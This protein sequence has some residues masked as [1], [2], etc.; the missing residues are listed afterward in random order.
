[1]HMPVGL[2]PL[3]APRNEKSRTCSV[4]TVNGKSMHTLALWLE[5]RLVFWLIVITTLLSLY[6]KDVVLLLGETGV[7]AEVVL[8]VTMGLFLVE[9]LLTIIA[10]RDYLCTLTFWFD[11]IGTMSILLDIDWFIQSLFG[12][13]VDDM[14]SE[15]KSLILTRAGKAMRI[16]TQTL[17]L[18]RLFRVI[19]LSRIAR[20]LTTL[21]R[22]KL[23]YTEDTATNRENVQNTKQ[24]I[25]T[26]RLIRELFEIISNRITVV[27][28]VLLITA[29]LCNY[30]ETNESR[31]T[32][33]ATI[34]AFID[35]KARDSFGSESE[36]SNILE[37]Q[38][39]LQ[40]IHV[41][42]E[43]HPDMY[44]LAIQG[45]IALDTS[46]TIPEH[47]P[48]FF[49]VSKKGYCIARFDFTE[50]YKNTAFYSLILTTVVLTLLI[51]GSGVIAKKTHQIVLRH[52]QEMIRILKV[53]GGTDNSYKNRIDVCKK[54]G[55]EMETSNVRA[56]EEKSDKTESH[57]KKEDHPADFL[58]NSN[59]TPPRLAQRRPSGLSVGISSDPLSLQSSVI[60]QMTKQQKHTKMSLI[61][62]SLRFRR[63]RK[64]DESPSG[65]D[66]EEVEPVPL[67]QCP[68]LANLKSILMDEEALAYF[69]S[70]M[71]R[72]FS[73]E[74]L[75]FYLDATAF[76]NGV[77]SQAK[78][79]ISAYIEPGSPWEINISDCT[80][81]EVLLLKDSNDIT[82]HMFMH[83]ADEIFNLMQRDTWSRFVNSDLCLEYRKTL[84]QGFPNESKKMPQT[85]KARS[86]RF[87]SRNLSADGVECTSE[88]SSPVECSEKKTHE[89]TS[90]SA[91][92]R[93]PSFVVHGKTNDSEAESTFLSQI[94]RKWNSRRPSSSTEISQTEE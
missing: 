92:Q 34:D 84:A 55:N 12:T 27:V 91:T 33:L 76:N 68:S 78:D 81:R 50:I 64:A 54:R 83:A 21:S 86:K 35:S 87:K 60:V 59:C 32:A 49:V 85:R 66:S 61:R 82:P 73:A 89:S 48:S 38:V 11:F 37:S 5:S 31:Q 42:H 4:R 20:I 67:S 15:E 23:K 75:L 80:R 57:C 79:I 70:F 2:L 29:V 19:R 40:L 9:I 94:R 30:Q 17:R 71:I 45:T 62:R 6:I 43:I 18:F 3:Y 24:E 88:S 39:L 26:N 77:R 36:E 14:S 8:V 56:M 44:Y 93:R 65:D 51:V 53:T 52:T 69:K 90:G 41:I 72:E 7:W 1:M 22:N 16:G 25:N 74:N 13:E 10:R 28:F 47:S 58:Q 63:D 46:D